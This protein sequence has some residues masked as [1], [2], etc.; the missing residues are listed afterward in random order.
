MSATLKIKNTTLYL[1]SEPQTAPS[2]RSF[3]LSGIKK[4]CEKPPKWIDGGYKYHWQYTFRYL[5]GNQEFFSFEVDYED[6]FVCKL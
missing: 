2:G 6:K 1:N 5:D 4:V 3:R